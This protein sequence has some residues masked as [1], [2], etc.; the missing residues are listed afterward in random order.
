[1][2]SATD[3]EQIEAIA[4]SNDAYRANPDCLMFSQ[5]TG[6]FGIDIRREL[7]ALVKNAPPEQTDTPY[8][9]SGFCEHPEL[10]TIQWHIDNDLAASPTGRALGIILSAEFD[11]MD[12][13]TDDPIPGPFSDDAEI[14][15][16][17]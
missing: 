14:P 12:D 15:F 1:M 8:R 10:G 4:T 16:K 7:I 9:D 2:K 5:Q 11:L 13:E 17:G 3:P 6:L